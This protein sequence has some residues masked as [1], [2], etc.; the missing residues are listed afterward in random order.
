[1]P[2]P[3]FNPDPPDPNNGNNHEHPIHPHPERQP[4]P[5]QPPPPAG[6]T[7]SITS[8]TRLEPRSRDADMQRTISARIFDP[9][10]M[11]TRQWQ[12]GEFQ[13]EDTGS[14]IAARVRAQSAL[15]SRVYLGELPANTQTQAP[16]YDSEKVPLEVIVERRRVRPKTATESKQLRLSVDAGLH[17]LRLLNNSLCREVI[18]TCLF[19]VTL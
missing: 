19:L 5:A 3:P 15:L 10:W 18:E 9:L 1:M 7:P 14:P 4:R 13:G 8:W 12:V 16:S 17:F 2:P 11:L 6:E